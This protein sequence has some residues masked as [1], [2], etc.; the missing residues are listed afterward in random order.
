M[1]GRARAFTEARTPCTDL[2]QAQVSLAELGLGDMAPQRQVRAGK[3]Y[4]AV[5]FA[6]LEVMAVFGSA[7]AVAVALAVIMHD[8]LGGEPLRSS[9]NRAKGIGLSRGQWARAIAHLPSEYFAVSKAPGKP[10]AVGLTPAGRKLF[11]PQGRS[12]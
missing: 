3:P 10:T 2:P 5:R 7:P 1:R 12:V 4:I 11:H 6:A 8:R 9:Q